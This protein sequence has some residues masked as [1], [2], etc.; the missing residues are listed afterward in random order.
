MTKTRAQVHRSSWP[1]G[2]AA[3]L[4]LVLSIAPAACTLDFPKP[5][6]LATSDSG[7]GERSFGAPAAGATDAGRAAAPDDRQDERESKQEQSPSVSPPAPDESAQAQDA[8]M[9]DAGA[10]PPNTV[11]NAANSPP[12]PTPQSMAGPPQPPAMT[13]AEA[14]VEFVLEPVDFPGSS[15]A[16]NF[17]PEALPPL[18][19]S[20]AFTWRGVPEGTRSL[21]LVFRDLDLELVRWVIWDIPPTQ[22]SLPSDISSLPNPPEVAGSSQQGSPG[23]LGYNGPL[24]PGAEYD[25]TLW[26]L[27]VEMLPDT[28]AASADYIVDDLLPMHVIATTEPVLVTNAY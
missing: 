21:A 19:Q 4:P 18:S 14:P 13:E 10:A 8:V 22:T 6:Q 9:P 25:F 16:L 11:G 27:D 24:I 15:G 5:D 23:N 17:P 26:A 3:W 7:A 20:P 12:T 1:A 28:F 2:A